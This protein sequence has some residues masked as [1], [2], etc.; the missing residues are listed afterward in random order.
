MK[1]TLN[2]IPEYKQEE[3]AVIV[4]KIKRYREQIGS[5]EMIILFG[6][7]ARGDFVEK[8]Y[9]IQGGFSYEFKSD[10]DIFVVTKKPTQEKN[11]RLANEME[12]AIGKNKRIKTP[13]SII[14]EDIGYINARLK[15]NHYF[16]HD[17]K[18]EGILL[19]DS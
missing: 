6:S 4:K 3:I 1:T 10:F 12:T 9:S 16:Y 8:D 2:H 5:I 18:K 19:Y 11:M 17:L 13:V 15:E 14:V 7:Y